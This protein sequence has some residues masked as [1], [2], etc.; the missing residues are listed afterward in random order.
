VV[1]TLGNTAVDF[2]KEYY[3]ATSIVEIGNFVYDASARLQKHTFSKVVFITSVAKMTK[4]AQGFKNTHNKFGSIDF[5][6][7]RLWIEKE[8]HYSLEDEEFLTLKGVL[9]TLPKEYHNDFVKFI[10][11]KSAEQFKK[12]FL[13]LGVATQEIEIITLPQKVKVLMQ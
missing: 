6:E 13:E 8:L 7:V 3:A 9:Q 2:A 11:Q 10:T 5:T 1:F 4:V 12:W